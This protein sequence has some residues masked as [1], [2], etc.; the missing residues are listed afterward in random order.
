M[1]R[2]KPFAP[3]YH[4][5]VGFPNLDL[6]KSTRLSLSKAV[7]CDESCHLIATD[8]RAFRLG[9]EVSVTIQRK[10]LCMLSEAA[11]YASKA[12][13]R[14]TTRGTAGESTFPTITAY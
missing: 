13:V 7:S 2:V 5:P 11:R 4:S 8:S 9:V 12:L 3:F 6:H 14:A 1:V 10:S